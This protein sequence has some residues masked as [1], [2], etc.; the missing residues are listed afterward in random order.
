MSSVQNNFDPVWWK[1]VRF[2]VLNKDRF[3]SLTF[4]SGGTIIEQKHFLFCSYFQDLYYRSIQSLVCMDQLCVPKEESD[5]SIKQCYK[6]WK[7]EYMKLFL[8]AEM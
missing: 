3:D 8:P 4:S 1:V 5:Y 2:F 6:M 7:G